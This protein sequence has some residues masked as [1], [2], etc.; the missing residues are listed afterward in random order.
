M[1]TPELV[2]V[3]ARYVKPDLGVHTEEEA[4]AGAMRILSDR[5]GRHPALRG[6]LRR[7][8]RKHGV[9]RV[10]AVGD[11]SKLGRHKALLKQTSTLAQLQ[12]PRLIQLRQAQRER[13][14]TT[15]LEVD[16]ARAMEKVR[17]SL[18][19][20]TRPEFEGVLTAVAE[21]ALVRR[22]LPMLE[23]DVR[24][25]LKE[26]ADEEALRSLASHLRQLLLA[27]ALGRRA[28][29]GI[30]VNAK[31]DLTV[32]VVDDGGRP[33]GPPLV[34]ETA[35][36]DD[37][38]LAEEL[39]TALRES[40]VRWLAMGAS[41]GLRPAVQRVRAAMAYLGADASLLLVNDVGLSTY[42]NSEGARREL[43][44]WTAPGRQA[45]SLARRLQDPL[46]E[47][48]KLEPRHLGLGFE[49]K[50]V[51]KANLARVLNE[52]VESAVASVGCDLA[53]APLEWLVR[54]PG[55]D[56]EAA[57][58]LIAL[59]EAG[60]PLSREALRE[61]E[62]LSPSAWANAI[63]FLRM[64]GSPEPLD[65]GALHPEQYDLARR[66]L[67]AAGL[68]AQEARGRSGALK[69]LKRADFDADEAT[70]RDLMRELNHPGRDPRLRIFPLRLLPAD[71]APESLEKGQVIEGVVSA[72][73]NFGAFVDLGLSKEGLVHISELGRGFVRDGREAISIG[74]VV[75]ARVLDPTGPRIQLSLKEVPPIER[76]P[77]F[78]PEGSE[79]EGEGGKRRGGGRRQDRRREVG[80]DGAWPQPERMVRAASSR[81]DL[82]VNP[83]LRSSE[84]RSGGRPRTGGPGGPGGPGGSGGRGAGGGFG[85]GGGG[86]RGGATRGGGGGGGGRGG[87]G[88]GGSDRGGDRGRD[89]GEE[90]WDA[91]AARSASGPA[92][93]GYNPFASFFKEK[94]EADTPA[95][96]AEE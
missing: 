37:H 60:E 39:G 43:A 55:V 66:V 59:R 36:K 28:V 11:E 6:Q 7:M 22:L 86:G 83:N 54:L 61:R 23:A 92:K 74:Q 40:G 49:Q 20:H 94:P 41:R 88:R 79:G 63:G 10:R 67:D 80:S 85:G 33:T 96:P 48:L 47:F 2:R 16:P 58:R 78:R 57:E 77:R 29:A 53:E 52:T 87:F 64:T 42:A 73:A 81:R 27:P 19:R 14:V 12:G 65:H 71:T 89:A 3:C 9:L 82:P 91:A 95:S 46:S 24:L 32:A 15:H 90:R 76:G 26:R 30:D 4:L 8:L 21:R 93:A 45:V 70:W 69:G 62:V 38:A 17:Q 75:R 34:L 72:V 25:E 35:E 18:G 1:V 56:R 50:L 44:D 5:L 13:A 51:S 68:T 31:G 84:G